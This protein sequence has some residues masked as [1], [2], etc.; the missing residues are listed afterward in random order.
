MTENRSTARRER[1]S[2]LLK[3]AHLNQWW[4]AF[5]TVTVTVLVA[6]VLWYTH[7]P[8]YLEHYPV[9]WWFFVG[10]VLIIPLQFVGYAMALRNASTNHLGFGPVLALEVGE[11]VTAMATPESVGSFALSMRFLKRAGLDTTSSVAA[12]GLASFVTSMVAVIVLPIAVILAA[13][14][15]NYSQLKS[16]V[17]SGM[18]EIILGVIAVAVFVTV[19]IKA[20]TVRQRVMKS[21]HSGGEY[22]RQV[23]REPRRSLLIGSAELVTLIGEVGALSLLVLG[24]RQHANIPALIVIVLVASTASSVVPIPGGLGAPE[25]ILVA[26]LASLGVEHKA[27]LIAAVSY[28]LL[29]YWIPPLPGLV[30]LRWLAH[31]DRL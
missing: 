1:F 16:D 27:A 13:S 6:F 11:S 19:L 5:T 17:P 8:S 9:R 7:L 24:V 12:V 23:I 30:C 31:T 18:W 2:E 22:L 20:P 14:T 3:D 25:A 28:R 26:G 29:S 21:L 10:A 4:F 15:I